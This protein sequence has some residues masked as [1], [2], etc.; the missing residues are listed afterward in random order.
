VV[1]ALAAVAVA[2]AALAGVLAWVF[3]SRSSASSIA[4]ASSPAS[5]G[6]GVER[7]PT[8]EPVSSPRKPKP[9][10]ATKSAD[11]EFDELMNE[12]LRQALKPPTAP[13]TRK[14]PAKDG[15]SVEI[16]H[17]LGGEAP[18][19][20]EKILAVVDA[21]LKDVK[22]CY[23]KALTRDPMLQGEITLMLSVDAKGAVSGAMCAEDGKSITDAPLRTCVS[24]KATAWRFAKPK[25]ATVGFM[26]T[27][28]FSP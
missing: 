25:D 9:A 19:N 2:L 13:T 23:T 26:V 7:D 16:T 17:V 24:S 5:S 8:K 6:E 10:A 27:L 18:N 4:S 1:A 28:D 21:N 22:G 11:D 12:S 15:P 3:V 14:R 20:E